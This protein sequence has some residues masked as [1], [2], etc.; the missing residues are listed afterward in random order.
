MGITFVAYSPLG[1]GFLTGAFRSFDDLALDDWRRANPR[2]QG[3]NFR[4]NLELVEELKMAQEK[5]VSAA[6]VGA[7]GRDPAGGGGGGNEVSGGRDAGGE[8]VT[9]VRPRLAARPDVRA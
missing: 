3:D 4:K 7:A 2:F 9:T 8:R 1:R 5:G 6:G